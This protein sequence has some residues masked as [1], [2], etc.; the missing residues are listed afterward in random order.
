M[1]REGG[2]GRIVIGGGGIGRVQ[3]GRADGEDDEPKDSERPARIEDG[4]PTVRRTD[5]DSVLELD[6]RF[7]EHGTAGIVDLDARAREL[8]GLPGK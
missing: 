4:L 2:A 5:D 7:S 3:F 6:A 1:T 8:L